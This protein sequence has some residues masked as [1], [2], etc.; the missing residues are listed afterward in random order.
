ML[1][2]EVLLVCDV[3]AFF[4]LPTVA[5]YYPLFGCF[6]SDAFSLV[7]VGAPVHC[8]VFVVFAAA[9]FALCGC[10]WW[11]GECYCCQFAFLVVPVIA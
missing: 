6:A 2:V 7:A 8:V 5:V 11:W 4:T 1:V 9:L 10:V 3:M